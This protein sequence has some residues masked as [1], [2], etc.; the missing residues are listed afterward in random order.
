[1]PRTVFIDLESLVVHRIQGGSLK[2][3]FEKKSF[4]SGLED[5]VTIF[6]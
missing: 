4:I 3:L 2:Q 6:M 1:M 5:S